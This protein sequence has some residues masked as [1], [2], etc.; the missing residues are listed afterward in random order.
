MILVTVTILTTVCSVLLMTP[1]AA[2]AFRGWYQESG[3]F[4]MELLPLLLL[5]QVVSL[6]AS[7]ET[8]D[9]V[10]HVY[11][12]GTMHQKEDV[13]AVNC[14]GTPSMPTSVSYAANNT[15]EQNPQSLQ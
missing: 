5:V 13:S 10:L 12:V 14:W 6:G 2:V 3:G 7:P 11:I 4:P 15:S 9:K 1:T 8:E